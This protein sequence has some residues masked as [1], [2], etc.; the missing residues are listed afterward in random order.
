MLT[1][2]VDQRLVRPLCIL[3]IEDL[4]VLIPYLDNVRLADVLDAYSAKDDPLTTFQSIFG[5]F[6]RK[7][8]IAHRRNKWIDERSEEIW[9]RVKDLFIDL[10]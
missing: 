2:S 8:R 10:S 3:S 4:E 9:Q 5:R 7:R 6:R 1:R